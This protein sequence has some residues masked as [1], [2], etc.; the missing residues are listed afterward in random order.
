V[1]AGI[2]TGVPTPVISASLYERFQSRGN[3]EFG[4]KILSALREEFGGHAEKKS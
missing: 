3:G 2:D 1:I 4:D